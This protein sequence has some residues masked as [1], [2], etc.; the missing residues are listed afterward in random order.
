MLLVKAAEV[1]RR[2]GGDFLRLTLGDRTGQVVAMVWEEVAEAAELAI[3]GRPVHVLGRYIV[4]P[5][6]GPQVN[7]RSLRPAE[8][9]SFQLDELLDGPPRPAEQM[10]RDLRS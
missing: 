10:E 6:Y 7:L 8:P 1:R 2:D 5:R 3:A 4:H 9:G